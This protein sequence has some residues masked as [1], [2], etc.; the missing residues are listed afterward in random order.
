MSTSE[1]DKEETT[2]TEARN[3]EKFQPRNAEEEEGDPA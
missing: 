1:V 2:G 3:A